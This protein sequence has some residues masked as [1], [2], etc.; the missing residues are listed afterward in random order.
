MCQ[1]NE[2]YGK[3]GQDGLAVTGKPTFCCRRFKE[4]YA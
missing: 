2:C 1:L 3:I 4:I